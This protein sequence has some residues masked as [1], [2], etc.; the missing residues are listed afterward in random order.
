[1]RQYKWDKGSLFESF[2]KDSDKVQN[3]AG[4]RGRCQKQPIQKLTNFQIRR[5]CDICTEEGFSLE[6]MLSMPCGHEF[7]LECWRGYVDNMIKDGASSIIAKCPQSG[8]PE[9]VTEE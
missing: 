9:V 6:K 7:C 4:V 5:Y 2:F 1:M 8:C 3:E